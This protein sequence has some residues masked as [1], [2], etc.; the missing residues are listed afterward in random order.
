MQVNTISYISRDYNRIVSVL[1]FE[2]RGLFRERIR[3]LDKKIRPGLSKL[4]WASK[5]IS[6]YFVGECR[7]HAKK[8]RLNF[9]SIVCDSVHIMFYIQRF[10]LI[11]D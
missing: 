6:E 9:T 5:G 7:G 3:S 1:S 11:C 4:T 10:K 2:E 8:V